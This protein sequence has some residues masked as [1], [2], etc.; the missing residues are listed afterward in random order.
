MRFIIVMGI[1]CLFMC[2]TETRI[3]CTK[4]QQSHGLWFQM[5]SVWKTLSNQNKPDELRINLFKVLCSINQTMPRAVSI[6]IKVTSAPAC[7][8]HT[9]KFDHPHAA[10]MTLWHII[11]SMILF[12]STSSLATEKFTI[13][14]TTVVT[15][16]L[17]QRQ[18]GL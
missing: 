8:H 3:I 4:T 5:E 13:V 11:C 2:S 15:E 9:K 14:F 6:A 16:S 10:I 18:I 7:L 12:I 1:G 17:H